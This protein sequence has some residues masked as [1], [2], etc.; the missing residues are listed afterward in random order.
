MVGEM[1]VYRV[2]FA[3]AI[4]FLLH[5]VV[6]V[7]VRNSRDP[8]AAFQNGWWGVKF[9]LFAGLVTA[10]FFIPNSFFF[11]WGWVGVVG[12]FLF[13]V[14]QLVFLN[15]FAHAWSESWVG[16]LEDTGNRIWYIGLATCSFLMYAVTLTLT[17]LLYVFYAHG[18]G[19][20]LNKFYVSFNLCLAVVVS[21]I[22]IL[23]A[24][25]EANP[26]SGLLQSSVVSL[27]ATYL[28]W[29]A[30][31]SEP[32]GSLPCLPAQSDATQ[33][34]SIAIGTVFAFISIAYSSVR[35]GSRSQMGRIGMREH[36]PDT[37]KGENEVALLAPDR[38]V[39]ME[40]GAGDDSVTEGDRRIVD[41]ER[42]RIT[43]SYTFF[44][45]VFFIASLYIME[46]LTNWDTISQGEGHSIAVGKSWAAV[47][48]KMASSWVV[49]AIYAWSL[50][51]PI[52]LPDRDFN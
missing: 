39:Q 25:Q 26:R 50:V 49:M 44:H 8:R 7:H 5:A 21:L 13:I 10:S 18:D 35:T 40:S 9:V 41:D 16:R 32:A 38:L 37:V 23:P 17:V 31:S 28:V 6:L 46:M 36:T 4:F 2:C 1:G 12:A 33:S 19:C 3:M 30:I 20:A 14:I 52:V 51:A 29:S 27:Y 34:T 24:V 42:D 45:F 47:W 11:G 22:A 43:Y 15:E 48:V